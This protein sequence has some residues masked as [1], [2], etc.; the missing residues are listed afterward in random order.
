MTSTNSSYIMTEEQKYLFDLNGYLVVP[1]V[2]SA[3]T[4]RIWREYL[5]TLKNDPDSLP[6]HERYSAIDKDPE[7]LHL[8][9]GPTS[10]RMDNPTLVG[11]LNEILIGG[12]IGA[13]YPDAYPWRMESCWA[14]IKAAGEWGVPPHAP[15]SYTHL[16][17]PTNREV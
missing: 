13:G 5:I 16:T 2:L 8:V 17:L 14:T 12:F 10:E 15:V 6:Y 11:I 7:T 9:T 3:E 4:C 1:G